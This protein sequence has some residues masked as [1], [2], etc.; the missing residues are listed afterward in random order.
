VTD[1]GD[2]RDF[3]ADDSYSSLTVDHIYRFNFAAGSASLIDA[4]DDFTGK[5]VGSGVVKFTIPHVSEN[6]ILI[7]FK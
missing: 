3:V 2:S 5:D 6:P 7:R 1:D 4:T